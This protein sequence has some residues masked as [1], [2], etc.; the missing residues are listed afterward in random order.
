MLILSLDTGKRIKIEVDGKAVWLSLLETTRRH[1]G[2]PR[3]KL[4]FVAAP[5]I[6]IHREETLRRT[7]QTQGNGRH[8]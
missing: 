6:K 1:G 3:V 5:E 7:Q 2:Q 4:G 8:Q